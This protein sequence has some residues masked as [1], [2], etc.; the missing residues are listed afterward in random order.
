MFPAPAR[1]CRASCSFPSASLF[2]IPLSMT[3]EVI[4]K[5]RESFP[6]CKRRHQ[7]AKKACRERDRFFEPDYAVFVLASDAPTDSAVGCQVIS[8]V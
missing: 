2:S 3:S 7:N 5:T 1:L 6:T 4:N 8:V